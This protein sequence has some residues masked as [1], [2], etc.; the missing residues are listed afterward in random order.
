MKK[1]QQMPSE[2]INLVDGMEMTNVQKQAYLE[3]NER[4]QTAVKSG[5]PILV[6]KWPPD[7][8]ESAMFNEEN[9]YVSDYDIDSLARTLLPAIEEFYADPK[10]Q[11]EFEEWSQ[12]EE[13]QKSLC[14]HRQNGKE[15]KENIAKPKVGVE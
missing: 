7:S 2:A 3:M 6:S 11:K 13:G 4:E 10:N 14:L 15:E 1:Q 5:M 8:S 12:T 9:I